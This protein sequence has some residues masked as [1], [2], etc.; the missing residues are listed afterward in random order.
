MRWVREWTIP[1]KWPKL[2]PNF[3]DK[4]CHVV[5][6]TDLYRRILGF[7]DRNRYFF[8]Q[9]APQLYSRGWVDPVPDPLLLRKSNPDLWICSQELWPLDHRCGHTYLYS[10]I[11][12]KRSLRNAPRNYE[13]RRTYS[14]IYKRSKTKYKTRYCSTGFVEARTPWY[15]IKARISGKKYSST[16]LDTKRAA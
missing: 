4:G 15:H 11:N 2:V 13:V 14:S 6:A 8:F 12:F 1:T 3:A 10:H 5:G 7:L 16:F 9:A